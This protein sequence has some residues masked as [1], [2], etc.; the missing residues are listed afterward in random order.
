[1]VKV[2]LVAPPSSERRKRMEDNNQESCF[3][4]ELVEYYRKYQRKEHKEDEIVFE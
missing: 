4:R 2:H 3:E 1:M